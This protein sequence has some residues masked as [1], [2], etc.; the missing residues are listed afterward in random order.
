M[1]LGGSESQKDGSEI[2]GLC[3]YRNQPFEVYRIYLE[4]HGTYNLVTG[5]INEVTLLLCTYNPSWVNY[6][7]PY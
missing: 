7:L 6:S 1:A 2:L 3:R 5:V 4:E